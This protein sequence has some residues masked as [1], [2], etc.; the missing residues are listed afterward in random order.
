MTFL[1]DRSPVTPKRTMPQ[2]PAIRGNRRS[3]GSR[4][5]LV[6]V[7]RGPQVVVRRSGAGERNVVGCSSSSVL[8]VVADQRLRGGV[9]LGGHGRVARDRRPQLL[10]ELLAE[11]DAPLVEAVDAP[12]GA[13]DEG[14]VLVE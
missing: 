10:G 12:H 14:D 13:L 2:G 8:L 1:R 5:G 3:C 11:L 7:M 9:L 6:W 4:S